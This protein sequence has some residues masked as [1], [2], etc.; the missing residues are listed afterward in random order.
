MT[1]IALFA[2][3]NQIEDIYSHEVKKAKYKKKRVKKGTLAS[4]IKDVLEEKN[5]T[6]QVITT[7]AIKKR[8]TRKKIAVFNK[9][10]NISPL[11]SID[12]KIVD[13]I[14]H[15]AQICQCVTPSQG[16][17]L[18]NS[19]IQ[20][21]ESQKDIIEWNMRNSYSTDKEALGK[22]GTGYWHTF[23]KCQGHNLCSKK[24]QKFELDRS[25][26]STYATFN[27]MHSKIFEE[28]EDAGVAERVPEHV[29]TDRE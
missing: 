24:G 23:I 4:I 5:L 26:W 9:Q 8:F 7:A 13:I 3:K 22:V 18:V 25:S 19:V 2:S 20:R 16:I 1:K 17:N 6:G 29:W 10:G 21:T 28:M 14:V 12:P 11:V 27:H 15:M